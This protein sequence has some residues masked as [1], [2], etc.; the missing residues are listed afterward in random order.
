MKTKVLKSLMLI[1]LFFL[2]AG[3]ESEVPNL[4]GEWIAVDKKTPYKVVITDNM[5]HR[6]SAVLQSC[7]YTIS[8]DYLHIV[9]M[10]KSETDIDYTADCKYSL[11]GDTLIIC[12]FI[13]TIAA[14]YPPQYNDIKLVKVTNNTHIMGEPG[15]ESL[16]ILKFKN[17]EYK[18]YILTNRCEEFFCIH[19]SSTYMPDGCWENMRCKCPF[20]ELKQNYVLLDWRWT[21][22]F[23]PTILFES[24]KKQETWNQVWSLDTP[25]DSNPIVEI[26]EIT[27]EDFDLYTGDIKYNSLY[28]L[29][30]ITHYF[31]ASYIPTQKDPDIGYPPTNLDY[32][33]DMSWEELE[34]FYDS[35]YQNIIQRL[36]SI[37]EIKSLIEMYEEIY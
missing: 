20:N 15:F 25:H 16:T 37:M 4:Q 19:P 13:P 31:S 11:N 8:Q 34:T 29:P 35:Y 33:G 1:G 28:Y 18:D 21:S 30:Y 36:D 24:Y 17:P 9:R 7:K 6:Y 5:I 22:W 12:D 32:A 2:V 10:W 3:C 26:Y 27:I 23:T 14:T